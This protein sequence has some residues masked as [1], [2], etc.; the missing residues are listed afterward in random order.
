ML[1]ACVSSAQE[2]CAVIGF[3]QPN[4]DIER[5]CQER[6]EEPKPPDV[7][8]LSSRSILNSLLAVSRQFLEDGQLL[9]CPGPPLVGSVFGPDWGYAFA[10]IELRK[11]GASEFRLPLGRFEDYR[12]GDIWGYRMCPIDNHEILEA[13]RQLAHIRAELA[14]PRQQPSGGTGIKVTVTEL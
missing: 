7:F 11:D 2:K 6:S 1:E 14:K 9:A 8:L 10:E 13:I 12:D 4:V 5:I 3:E